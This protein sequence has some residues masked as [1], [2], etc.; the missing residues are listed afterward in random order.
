[1]KPK[2][3]KYFMTSM[4][5]ALNISLVGCAPAE[6]VS[7]EPIG[8]GTTDAFDEQAIEMTELDK[9]VS[10]ALGE[11]KKEQPFFGIPI[12]EETGTE[13]IEEMD[14][15]EKIVQESLN[16]EEETSSEDVSDDIEEAQEFEKKQD[17]EENPQL[18]EL[19]KLA[20]VNEIYITGNGIDNGYEIQL[21][22]PDGT[23]SYGIKEGVDE[24]RDFLDTLIFTDKSLV[25]IVNCEDLEIITA[26]SHPENIKSLSIKNC[27]MRDVSFLEDYKNL[28]KLRIQDCPNLENIDALWNLTELRGVGLV[29]TSI[30]DISALSNLKNI[31]YLDLRCNKIEDATPLKNLPRLQSLSLEYNEFFDDETLDFLVEKEIISNNRKQAILMT[32]YH[33]CIAISSEEYINQ[34][35]FH[36]LLIKKLESKE[37]W[38]GDKY[39]LELRDENGVS[40]L[41]TLIKEYD[42]IDLFQNTYNTITLS[43][44]DDLSILKKVQNKDAVTELNLVFCSTDNLEGIEAF[45]NIE[46]LS[47]TNCDSLSD[48][49]ELAST[50]NISNIIIK[51]TPISDISSLSSVEGLENIWLSYTSVEDLDA[52][53]NLPKLEEGYF[54]WNNIE[55]GADFITLRNKG[56][57][58]GFNFGTRSKDSK[59]VKEYINEK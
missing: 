31:I 36:E 3:L 14:S 40:C 52:L 47:I 34:T 7:I 22:Y 42:D 53:L 25:N 41:Y 19:K 20:T 58:V 8:I 26:I 27:P 54:Y 15:L 32:S 50:P 29:G 1:M 35:S 30:S 55:N 57:S 6:D 21:M 16:L 5:L 43:D 18:A 48:I 46:K 51:N 28:E 11:E 4:L 10:K 12:I 49:S 17:F 13:S 45:P 2:N 33:D 23:M 9:I 39:Y 24:T 38:S 56:V 59:Q 44:V 37:D